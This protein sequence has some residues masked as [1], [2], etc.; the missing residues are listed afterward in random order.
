MTLKISLPCDGVSSGFNVVICLE[1][2][3]EARGMLVSV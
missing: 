1:L 3:V 2:K